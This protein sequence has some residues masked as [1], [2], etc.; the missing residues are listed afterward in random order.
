MD[1]NCTLLQCQHAFTLF[2]GV[3]VLESTGKPTMFFFFY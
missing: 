3:G 2:N 1:V